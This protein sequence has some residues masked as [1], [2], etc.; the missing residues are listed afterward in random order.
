MTL[1]KKLLSVA[2]CDI[3]MVCRKLV[4]VKLRFSPV[5]LVSPKASL[6][7]EG[8]NSKIQIGNKCGIR[9]NSELSATN[10]VISLGDN[11]FI[12]R[13]CMIVAHESIS[14][15]DGTTVGP[16]TYI[17]DHDHDGNGGYTTAPVTIG[18]NVWIGAGCI[19]LKGVSLGDGSV[20]GAGSVITKR[21]PPNAVVIQ[22][23]TNCV[24]GIEGE[25]V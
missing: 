11:C 19:I 8:K 20:I 15:G 16:G 13:N 25:E 24:K 21:V 17:Y 2:A 9:P 6:R 3:G 22:K 12:N 10:A 5:S 4:G 7:T 23:R 14:I 1:I 18:K